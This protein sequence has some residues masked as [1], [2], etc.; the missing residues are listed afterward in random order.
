MLSTV[1]DATAEELQTTPLRSS[2]LK[3]LPELP[4]CCVKVACWLK[5]ETLSSFLLTLHH[6]ISVSGTKPTLP[7]LYPLTQQ[8]P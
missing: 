3:V 1:G 6:Q 8:G 2:L 4:E 7:N 5:Q